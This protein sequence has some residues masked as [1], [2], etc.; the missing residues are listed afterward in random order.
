MAI[1]HGVTDTDN[2]FLIDPITRTIDNE[3]GKHVLIQ[4]DHNSERY[5]F[6]CPRYVEGHDMSLCN[7]IEVHFVNTSTGNLKSVG[8]YEANDLHLAPDDSNVV[9]FSWLIHRNATRYVGK[10]NF[11]VRFTCFD[12]TETN[13]EY[14]WNTSIYSDISID[15]SIY[16]VDDYEQWKQEI[17][18]I[19]EISDSVTSSSSDIIASSKAVKTAYDKGVEAVAMLDE[20]YRL[21]D[22][23]S[24]QSDEAFKIADDAFNDAKEALKIAGE[25]LDNVGLKFSDL[26]KYISDSVTSNS[27]E[28]I[29]SSRA[30]KEAYDKAASVANSLKTTQFTFEYDDGTEETISV[31]IK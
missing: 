10:L 1:R 18:A 25:A 7:K 12:N 23:A 5:T 9:M 24:K 28:T 13:D 15:K 22:A 6:E 17:L 11:V 4:Y 21:S 19:L 29:A 8:I 26:R 2:H 14:I 16:N 27:S 20:A 3:S 30:V 31:Y